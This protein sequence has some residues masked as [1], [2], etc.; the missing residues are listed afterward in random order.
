MTD[1]KAHLEP[2]AEPW[3]VATI[4]AIIIAFLGGIPLV[5]LGLIATRFEDI[6]KEF[7]LGVPLP[8]RVLFSIGHWWYLAALGVCGVAFIL[9]WVGRSMRIP[10][11]W[12][13]LIAVAVLLAMIGALLYSVCSLFIPTVQLI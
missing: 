12:L 5:L 1:P 3:P 8:A 7:K 13:I 10:V 11:A 2:P 4:L 6:F 9:G